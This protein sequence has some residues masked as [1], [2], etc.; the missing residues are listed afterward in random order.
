[1]CVSCVIRSA[2]SSQ[3]VVSARS[4]IVMNVLIPTFVGNKLFVSQ[5][6]SA[7]KGRFVVHFGR[8]GDSSRG[9]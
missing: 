7:L 6:M 8:L 1:M 4:I 5:Y 9:G 3:L 2:P